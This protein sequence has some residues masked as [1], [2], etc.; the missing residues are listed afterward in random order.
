[1][2]CGPVPPLTP[3]PAPSAQFRP[4]TA[5]SRDTYESFVIYEFFALLKEYMGGDAGCLDKLR[6]QPM[7]PHLFPFCYMP[8]FRC[9][10][11]ANPLHSLVPP[12]PLTGRSWGGVRG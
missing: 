12:E 10:F 4:C 3:A 1:M 11:V 2:G 8:P 9:R 5:P 7:M 6:R